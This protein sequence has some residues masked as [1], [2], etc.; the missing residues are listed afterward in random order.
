[1]AARPIIDVEIHDEAFRKFLDLFKEYQGMLDEQPAGW[2]DINKASEGAFTASTKAMEEVALALSA[3]TAELAAVSTSL[4]ASVEHQ[5]KLKVA[6]DKTET[7]TAR[8]ARTAKSAAS[9]F[10]S[11]AKL[12]TIGGALSGLAT[13]VGLF[14]MDRLAGSVFG[15]R[16]SA[17]GLGVTSGQQAAFRVNYGNLIDSDSLLG[18]VAN[19]RNDLSQQWAFRAMGIGQDQEDGM[20]NADLSAAMTRRARDIWQHGPHTQQF[21]EARGL[22]QFFSME[23][24]RRLGSSSDADMNGA[25]TGRRRDEGSMSE[26]DAVQ[27]QWVELEK[28]LRRA[29][30]QIEASLV[31]GL[32]PLVPLFNSL[33][34]ELT[35][36]ITETLGS[37]GF[38]DGL[39][40]FTDWL[41][42]PAMKSD[43][44]ALATNIEFA[45]EKIAHFLRMIGVLPGEQPAGATPG[46]ANV[47]V[48]PGSPDYYD[49]NKPLSPENPNAPG[50]PAWFAAHPTHNWQDAQAGVRRA[51]RG[52][53]LNESG[54]DSQGRVSG[55][56]GF[57]MTDVLA[58]WKQSGI[59]LPTDKALALEDSYA[60]AAGVPRDFSARLFKQEAG[61]NP[62]GTARTSS[63]GAIGAGQLMPST[64]LGLGV[65]PYDTADNISG[66][67]QYMKQLLKQFGNDQE[68]AAAAYNWGPGAVEKDIAQYGADWKR[69][70]PNETAG[71]VAGAVPSGSGDGVAAALDRIRR[72]L[73]R[74]PAAVQVAVRNDTSARV[75]VTANQVAPQ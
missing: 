44:H 26:S 52:L 49:P 17:L 48:G 69:H 51:L 47:P 30:L 32:T 41:G 40:E 9:A 35:H 20:N 61:L 2:N 12:L 13:G 33:S 58:K 23:E 21:A 43:L 11:V 1:M 7:S 46:G 68:K 16:R 66:S 18:N 22:T 4:A 25:E 38:R 6:T 28:Q 71:Y 27:R 62:D 65:N 14:G 57:D 55:D 67:V 15:Q 70:L 3:V 39:K 72:S 60:L 34:G 36:L 31:N 64:A 42:S 73:N 50:S 37:S 74:P 45:G 54:A 10:T 5:N 53:G 8:L 29:G 59:V 63:A 56:V 19:G 75:A 24:L